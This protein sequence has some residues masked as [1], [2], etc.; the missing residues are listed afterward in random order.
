MGLFLELFSI[1]CKKK[2]VAST[3][4]I[5]SGFSVGRRDRGKGRAWEWKDR[6]RDNL[7][8]LESLG[9]FPSTS[10]GMKSKP[11]PFLKYILSSYAIHFSLIE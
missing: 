7:N 11:S 8:I 1:L 2:H 4:K 10:L 9:T 6:T 3:P 5:R